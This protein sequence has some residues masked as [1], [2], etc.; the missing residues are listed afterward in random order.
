MV[1]PLVWLLVVGLF[2]W[3]AIGKRYLTERRSRAT[4]STPPMPKST[5]PAKMASDTSKTTI[6]Q[7]KL[8]LREHTAKGAQCPCCHQRV[9]FYKRTLT[10]TMAYTL[11]ILERHFRT[12]SDW[13][14]VPKYLSAVGAKEASRGGDYAK[15]R[16]WGLIE[17]KPGKRDDD[18]SRTGYW[19]ITER[20]RAFVRGEIRV[21][22]IIEMYNQKPTGRGVSDETVSIQEALGVNF[23][24]SKLMAGDW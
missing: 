20:G 15:L 13:L 2:L 23:D 3:F 10:S 7:A 8:W 4:E 9:Q 6:A 1:E 11:I 5:E 17:P 21:H 14:H 16:D 22:K 24:Y 12:N 19:K 18:S